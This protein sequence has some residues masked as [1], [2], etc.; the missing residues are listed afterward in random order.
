MHRVTLVCGDVRITRY[1]DALPIVGKDLRVGHVVYRVLRC[2][3]DT[4]DPDRVHEYKV[5]LEEA[6]LQ[7]PAIHDAGARDRY[8]CAQMDER[9]LSFRDMQKFLR[10]NGLGDTEIA[11]VQNMRDHE[12][13]TG[14]FDM[15]ITP[16]GSHIERVSAP[17]GDEE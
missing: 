3:T 12:G 4:D 5:S 15:V 13:Y 14:A 11:R 8:R 17:T 2:D 10:D 1:F 9:S 6:R 7:F 16:I